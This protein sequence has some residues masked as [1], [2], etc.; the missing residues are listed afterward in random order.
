MQL[1]PLTEWRPSE[2][3]SSLTAR[4]ENSDD[5]DGD[6]VNNAEGRGTARDDAG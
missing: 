5:G 2:R 6:D 1:R 4:E 3:S